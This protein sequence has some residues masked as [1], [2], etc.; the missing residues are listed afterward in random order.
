MRPDIALSIAAGGLNVTAF[1][2]Y[3]W[4]TFFGTVR[5]NVVSWGVWAF[6]TVLNFTSYRAMTKDWVKS[7]LP[8]ISAVQCVLTFL[9]ALFVGSVR[10]LGTY[11][12]I[13]LGFG[14]MA[15]L[16]WYTRKSP[17][18][19]NMML[20]AGITIGFIPTFQSVWDAPQTEFALSWFLWTISFLCNIAVVILR[21]QGKWRDL[22][23]NVNCAWMHL[24]V[25]VLALR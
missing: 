22:V 8:T 19:A 24:V 20:Q 4:Q 18:A 15:S 23:Y 17:T 12:T 25:A 6:L 13:V 14:I 16:V 10:E 3:N 2:I 11:D 9:L 21:W 1:A 7:A 5:P